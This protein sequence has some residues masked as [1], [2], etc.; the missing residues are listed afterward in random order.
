MLVAIS[1]AGDFIAVTVISH[2]EPIFKHGATEQQLTQFVEQYAKNKLALKQTIRVSPTGATGQSTG[3][4]IKWIDGVASAT[5]SVRII[6]DSVLA[7]ALKAARAK[8]GI[9]G[10]KTLAAAAKLLPDSGA[11]P[12]PREI[13]EKKYLAATEIGKD[14]IANN[15]GKAFNKDFDPSPGTDPNAEGTTAWTSYLSAPEVGRAL[16]GPRPTVSSPENCARVTTLSW[17]ALPASMDFAVPISAR[18]LSRRT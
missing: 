8:L 6:N 11:T 4:D 1:P 16:L 2:N 3:N 7:S 14:L 12:Q 10:E 9:E 13:M 15:F 5:V 18:A 17:S